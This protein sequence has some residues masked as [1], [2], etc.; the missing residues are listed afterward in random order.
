M[1]MISPDTYI[2]GKENL[3]TEELLAEKSRL[4]EKI[5]KIEEDISNNVPD[6][7]D[8]GRSVRLNM[9]NKYVSKINELI[10]KK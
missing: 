8:G 10:S 3:S 4:E 5:K 6:V 1:E 9:Y 2:K 7:F